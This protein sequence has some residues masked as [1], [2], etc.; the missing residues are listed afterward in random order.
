[1]TGAKEL[2]RCGPGE[3]EAERFSIEVRAG[4]TT[5]GVPI[6]TV[7]AGSAI[8]GSAASEPSLEL[9]V[10]AAAPDEAGG[11]PEAAGALEVSGTDLAARAIRALGSAS[12]GGAATGVAGAG[13]TGGDTTVGAGAAPSTGDGTSSSA[14]AGATGC[15]SAAVVTGEKRPPGALRRANA[16][17]D[18]FRWPR[19]RS[20]RRATQT[21]SGWPGPASTRH[22][23]W[24]AD[25]VV[26][27]ASSS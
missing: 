15:A 19:E 23:K 16:H 24:N 11:R 10:D 13:N 18:Q 9:V 17:F 7:V 5:V 8:T 12:A 14:A 20:T 26:Q 25:A 21:D 6:S 27:A 2:L 1:M 4:G 3:D 22:E